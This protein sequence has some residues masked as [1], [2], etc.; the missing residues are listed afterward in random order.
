M[1]ENSTST[2][3][4]NFSVSRRAINDMNF[5]ESLR[6]L[7]NQPLPF[8]NAFNLKRILKQAQKALDAGQVQVRA[9]LA[10]HVE[11]D[12]NGKFKQEGGDFKF[13]DKAA[14]QKAYDAFLDEQVEF[15]CHKID[16]EVL[17][18]V[19]ISALQLEY[20]SPVLVGGE[21]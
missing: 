21:E 3:K 7:S 8:G 5:I 9:I 20:L 6:Y 18:R 17:Q 11:L 4:K 13:K 19:T 16:P 1:Q 15:S 2:L 12:E 10:E 14:F